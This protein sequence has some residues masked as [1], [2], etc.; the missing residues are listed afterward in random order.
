[1]KNKSTAIG[2]LLAF[3]ITSSCS[4]NNASFSKLADNATILAFG[5][6]LTKGNGAAPSQS[7]PSRLQ[8]LTQRRVINAGIS[9]EISENGLNRLPAL[10]EKHRP[11][12]VI[13]CHG[14]N[15]ILRHL[16]LDK[17]K[18]NIIRMIELTQSYQAQVLLLAV[19]KP[20]IWLKPVEIYAEIAENT[21]VGIDHYTLS[22]VLKNNA[23]KSDTYHP[24]AA[25]YAAMADAVFQLLS[26][27]G[28]I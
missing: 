10:L 8:Q 21:G 18:T 13:I 19:P 11:Q 26:Q 1:M 3:V 22:K 5:D 2:L 20:S 25:G 12:L 24:N 9:G 7:Y 28:A 16:R 23:L 14:G 27:Q 6:S 15:D 4:D 17:T